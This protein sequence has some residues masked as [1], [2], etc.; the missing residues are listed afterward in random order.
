MIFMAIPSLL[1]GAVLAQ[2]F[3]VLVLLPAT[4]MV[5]MAAAG[6]GLAQSYTIGA[7][8]LLAAAGSASMQA[9]YL[10]GLGLRYLLEGRS[11]ESPQ[12]FGASAPARRRAATARRQAI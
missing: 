4:L 1:V 6:I 12:S 11:V 3:K 7:T 10:F 2:R 9:G 8:V 5:L